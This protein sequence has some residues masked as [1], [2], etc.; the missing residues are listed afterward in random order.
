VIKSGIHCEAVLREVDWLY[1]VW[2]PSPQFFA[3]IASDL[4]MESGQLLSTTVQDAIIDHLLV[5]H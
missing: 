5:L 3:A 1:V 4:R 2:R